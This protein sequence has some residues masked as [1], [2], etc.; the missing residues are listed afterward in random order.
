MFLYR[1]FFAHRQGLIGGNTRDTYIIGKKT[2]KATRQIYLLAE[3]FIMA[4][5]KRGK[6]WH[7]YWKENK[8]VRSVSTG[9]TVKADAEKIDGL[10]K[11][12]RQWQK[13]EKQRRKIL[14]G[15]DLPVILEV[16][17]ETPKDHKR[18][19]I[20][21]DMMFDTAMQY[22]RLS[23]RHKR[24]FRHFIDWS[25]KTFADEITPQIALEYLRSNFGDNKSKTY[26]NHKTI[27]NT[28]FRLCAVEVG[29]PSPFSLIL[30]KRVD[31][32]ENHRSLTESEFNTIVEHASEPWKFLTVL[33]WNTGMPK[34][35]CFRFCRS[36]LFNV[37]GV[38]WCKYL[39]GKTAAFKRECQ[40][41]LSKSVLRM[42]DNLH[43]ETDDMPFVD[44][45]MPKI[46]IKERDLYFGDLLRK[47]SI[48]D[49]EDGIA[50]F[51]SLRSSFI[52]RCDEA[53]IPRHAIQSMIGHVDEET[54]NVYSHDKK[55][56]LMLLK[57]FQ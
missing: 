24:F 56:P 21:L 47:L 51:H 49:N 33:S 20:R 54:T 3:K 46:K 8:K 41:P 28:I 25:K 10:K 30:S 32:D 52:T 53:G 44:C 36:M 4:L 2:K 31:D 29:K 38:V 55:T 37:D 43:P 1:Q 9:L 34:E 40:V 5:I 22:R 15:S 50:D 57:V 48:V 26:N 13:T 6:Y 11:K 18:G 35:V 14:G 23:V 17:T 16:P 42:I 12:E 19:S 7:I 45:I 27:L 39:R